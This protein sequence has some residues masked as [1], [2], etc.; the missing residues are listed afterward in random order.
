M[1]V[2]ASVD[3]RPAA[4]H[5]MISSL[6]YRQ[7]NGN[8]GGQLARGPT[9]SGEVEIHHPKSGHTVWQSPWSQL[10]LPVVVAFVSVSSHLYFLLGLMGKKSTK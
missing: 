3:C 6:L 10:P 1:V 5:L 7:E 2:T 8:S 4:E 9:V